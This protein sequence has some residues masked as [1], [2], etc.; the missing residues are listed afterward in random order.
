MCHVHYLF[1]RGFFFSAC[2]SGSEV[3]VKL[4]VHIKNLPPLKN[5]NVGVYDKELMM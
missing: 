5:D 4:F 3:I 2:R 1:L